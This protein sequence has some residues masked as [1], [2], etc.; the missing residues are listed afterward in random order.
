MK[1]EL[2]ELIESWSFNI[3]TEIKKTPYKEFWNKIEQQKKR[4]K[5]IAWLSATSFTVLIL[6]NI[7][8]M[9]TTY[10]YDNH[11]QNR[12]ELMEY[13]NLNQATNPYR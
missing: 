6:L 10:S 9:R 1:S 7:W 12:S 8:G 2:E 5:T 4:N 11:L 13:Y 3:P